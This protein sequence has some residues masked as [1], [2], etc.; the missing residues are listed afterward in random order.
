M[1]SF[2][3]RCESV[4]FGV[5]L[6]CILFRDRVQNIAIARRI[7]Q[8]LS[9]LLVTHHMQPACIAKTVA[10]GFI[11][12]KVSSGSDHTASECLSYCFNSSN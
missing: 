1:I 6:V 8:T 10:I 5:I 9:W 3:L 4:T 11:Y 12:I 7:F 2:D